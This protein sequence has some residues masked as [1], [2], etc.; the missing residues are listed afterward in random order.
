MSIHDF[1]KQQLQILKD[2]FVNCI[3]VTTLTQNG[4]NM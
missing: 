2:Y 1:L 3:A 4:R